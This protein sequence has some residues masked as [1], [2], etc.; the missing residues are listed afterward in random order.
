[1]RA[2]D[3]Y[4]EATVLCGGELNGE[5]VL[6]EENVDKLFFVNR[7]LMDL[8]KVRIYEMTADI[9]ANEKT[10]DAIICGVAYY[11]SVKYCRHETAAF[12]S[13]LYNCKRAIALSN[14]SR[15]KN[16]PFYRV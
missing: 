6:G 7:A 2:I 1:M 12:L 3:I 16:S 4:R 15:V 13:E 11:I 5:Y 14:V 8:R 10:I 9:I